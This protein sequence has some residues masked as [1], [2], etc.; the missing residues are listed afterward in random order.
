MIYVKTELGRLAL[1]NRSEAM[2][3]KY[4]FPFLMCDGR[5]DSAEILSACNSHGFTSVDWYEMEQAGFIELLPATSEPLRTPSTS[6]TS[7]TSST[8]LSS[9][10][11]IMGSDNALD[12]LAQFTK[13]KK[14]ASRHLLDLL[15][16]NSERMCRQLEECKTKES[17]EALFEK[18]IDV[19]V[20]ITSPAKAKAYQD[21]VKAGI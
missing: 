1:K 4:H 9:T 7:S 12:N 11:S 10:N 21:R 16:P 18:Y 6:L 20:Q 15:G 3:R 19:V 14:N 8:S 2:P 17:F 5:R 13:L